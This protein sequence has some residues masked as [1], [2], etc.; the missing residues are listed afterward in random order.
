LGNLSTPASVQKLQTALQT[1][2]KE[3]P[4]FRFYALYDKMYRVDVLAHAYACCRAKRGAAG[5]DGQEFEHIEAYGR[6]RWLGE[7]AHALRSE[8][9]APFPVVKSLHPKAQWHAKASGHS[10][11]PGPRGANGGGFDFRA[12]L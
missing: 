11:D 3:Y 8:T 7:L 12:D 10:D 6:E 5:V 9:Y 4:S 1:K 2:A